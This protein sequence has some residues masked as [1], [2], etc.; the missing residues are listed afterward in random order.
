MNPGLLTAVCWAALS[1]SSYVGTGMAA[2]TTAQAKRNIPYGTIDQSRVPVAYAGTEKFRYEIGY[3]GGLKL[4]ELHLEVRPVPGMDNGYELNALVTTEDSIFNTIY[5]VRDVHVTR[6][7]GQDRLP[8]SYEVSQ[9]EGY[10]YEAHKMTR[11]DQASGQISYQK[12]DNEP[13]TYKVAVPI[14]NEFSSFFGSRLMPFEVGSSFLVPTFAD[15][16]RVDVE[17]KIL[18][19]EHFRKTAIGPVNTVLVSPIL[20]FKGL[21]DKR[22]DTAIWY[23]DD[24]CRV[25]V[26]ITSKLAIGSITSTLLEYENPACSKYAQFAKLDN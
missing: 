1:I 3:T 18:G 17:V 19:K 4:G 10:S 15:K 13:V 16:K 14:H 9:K 24:E 21:Y 8:Y 5:P 6:V 22:G 25:P 11:Y 26:K 7:S 23:T 12:D 20:K 2:E